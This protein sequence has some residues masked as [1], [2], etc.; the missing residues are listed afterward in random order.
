[1]RIFFS[2][3]F[4][5]PALWLSGQKVQ[6]LDGSS[7]K[8]LEHVSVYGKN[9]EHSELT[10]PKGYFSLKGF[11]KE[12]SL[13][14]QLVGYHDKKLAYKQVKATGSVELVPKPFA[15]EEVVVS[16]DQ[17]EENSSN[18]PER[19]TSIDRKEVR[20]QEPQTSADVLGTS[21]EVYIQKSQ[22]GGGSPMIRGF[23]TN[24]VL[25]VVDG[26]RMNNAIFRGG[27]LQNVI[28]L[29]P[30]VIERSEVVFGPGSMVYGS[31]AIGGVM[32][33]QTLEPELS[34]RDSLIVSG[35]AM[36][37]YSSAN[38]EYTG[39]VDIKLGGENWGSVTSFTYS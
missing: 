32:A 38:D 16:A 8:A 11:S 20:F 26:V 39:H 33:F 15:T 7:K 1:M 24:R 30:N 37:R 12:D 31:D 17:W 27:N 2:F 25:L 19:V 35:N 5:L 3:L 9:S 22:L 23:A 36:G 21:G 18:A 6:V 29:D 14:F 13:R 28:S 4:L 34:H 10:D